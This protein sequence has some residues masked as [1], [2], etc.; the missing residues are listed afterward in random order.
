MNTERFD[1]WR[2]NYDKLSYKAHQ[3][4]YSEIYKEYPTQRHGNFT[5]IDGYRTI[6]FNVDGRP[7][8]NVIEVGGWDGYLASLILPKCPH[9][10][11]WHNYEICLDLKEQQV[12][13]DD[14]YEL[15]FT[16][17]WIWQKKLDTNYNVM[18]MSHVM[19]HMRCSNFVK[20]IDGIMPDIVYIEAPLDRYVL[21]NFNNYLGTHIFE[22]NMNTVEFFMK[23]LGYDCIM[24]L[25]ETIRVFKCLV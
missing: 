8:L 10:A 21:Q 22:Y 23:E 14:R 24:K 11:K 16:D 3:E 19:E 25:G 7:N 2:E 18:I 6:L 12:P 4:F 1:W 20:L 15:R 17:D 5:F 9:I 13:T